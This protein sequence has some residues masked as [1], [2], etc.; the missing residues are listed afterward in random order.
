MASLEKRGKRF[1]VVFRLGGEKYFASVKTTDKRE[2]EACLAR[3]DENLRLVERGRL[4]IPDGADVGLFLL[5]DGK[6]EQKVRVAHVLTVGELVSKYRSTFTVGAKEKNTARTEKLHLSHAEKLFGST[7]PISQ[8]TSA[9]IQAYIDTR[10]ATKYKGRTIQSQTIKK[11]VATLKYVWNWASRNGHVATRF[12]GT[13]LVFPKTKLKEP[14]RTLDQIKV[15]VERGGLTKTQERELWDGLY[16]NPAEIAE[17]LSHIRERDLYPWLYPFVAT[18]AYTGARRSELLR[19]RVDDFDFTNRVLILREKKRSKDR[20]TFRSIE[21]TPFIEQV[22]RNYFNDTHPGGIFA[23]AEGP[24]IPVAGW[25]NTKAF[26]RV[27]RGSKWAFVKGYHTF[28]HSFVSVLAMSGVDQRLI[29][30]MSG[31]QTEEMRIRYRHLTPQ[32]KRAAL[33][34]VFSVQLARRPDSDDYVDD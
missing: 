1:R 21:M 8:V 9:T 12:P 18:A 33:E 5:S 29:D 25:T 10:A 3:L 34:S 24:N 30:E 17:V 23:F 14:F 27:L 6:L 22:M 7:T 16:L 28:R 11:E 20:E 26:R 19:A 32:M 15:I 2:A 4:T 31:H 13:N